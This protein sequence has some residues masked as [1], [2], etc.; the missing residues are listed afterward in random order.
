MD[1][2][3]I[4][5]CRPPAPGRTK[6]LQRSA[7][8]SPVGGHVDENPQ[9]RSNL[10]RSQTQYSSNPADPTRRR[11]RDATSLGGSLTRQH[12]DSGYLEDHSNSPPSM[13]SEMTRSF[14]FSTVA[15]G[16]CPKHPQEQLKYYCQEHDELVCADCLA[17][18]ARHQGHRHSRAD[19]VVEQQRSYLAEHLKPIV[20]FHEQSEQAI[21]V[22]RRHRQGIIQSAENVKQEITNHVESLRD[23][24][25]ARLEQLHDEV[26]KSTQEKLSLH[27]G[28][29]SYL[30]GISAQLANIIEKITQATSDNSSDI[31]FL[32]KQ[33]VEFASEEE[34]KFRAIPQEVFTPIQG[35][36]LTFS[37]DT[38]TTDLC[39]V[40][41][42]I[43]EKL[44]DAGKSYMNE[45][46]AR[47]LTVNQPG[48]VNLVVLDSNGQPY[49]DHVNGLKVEVR[50]TK[51]NSTIDTILVRDT[52]QPHIYGIQFTPTDACHYEVRAHFGNHSVRNSPLAVT[53][54]TLIAGTIVGEIRG[55]LQPN[56]IAITDTEV[57][58]V[59]NGKDCVSIFKHD[60]KL[61][62]SITGK[63]NK[64]FNRPRGVALIP[65]G[66]LLISDEDGLKQCTVEG[67]Q[68]TA[69][70]RPG[71]APMEFNCP[72]GIAVKQDGSIYVCDTY[73]K[74]V[75][76]L[77]PDVSFQGVLANKLNAPYDIA[78]N[79]YGELF[80]ADY[81]DSCVKVFS[82]N[83]KFER[84]F[85]DMGE[86]GTLR[87][88][89]SIHI[90]AN[91]HVFVGEEKGSGV[92]VFDRNGHFLTYLSAK[93]NGVFGIATDRLGQVYVCDRSNRKV[94]IFK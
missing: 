65:T 13:I 40:V 81:N 84:Q 77:S 35:T 79:T 23:M 45:L 43:S 61:V 36:T 8:V 17:L 49:V 90:D 68:L 38:I 72:G 24:L 92:A 71:S 63:G 69:L 64:K 70:G 34:R 93:S 59:E 28:R 87:S 62:R 52:E 57:V 39:Q 83:G 21:E 44:A 46:S 20:Q 55:V 11:T 78:I 22:M 67:K 73:N 76:I 37:P 2:T 41:G 53:V 47:G 15:G 82:G 91:D 48:C 89:V 56:G 3:A 50:S 31:L 1:S 32:H 25:D 26:D 30:E 86:R 88:P 33:L 85:S 80:V 10:Q 12:T 54:S 4:I 60:G 16:E 74:R 9:M 6:G 7:T 51:T 58:V 19:D 42:T 94:H 29:Q 66:H 75:Q 18:E 14:T 27:D 5:R